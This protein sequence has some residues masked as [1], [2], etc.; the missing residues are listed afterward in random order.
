M[1]IVQPK[2]FDMFFKLDQHHLMKNADI[3]RYFTPCVHK[4]NPSV[5]RVNIHKQNKILKTKYRSVEEGPHLLECTGS[6]ENKLH[7]LLG[8]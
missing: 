6:K 7:L 2:Y 8:G 3:S 1:S 5:P 4:I